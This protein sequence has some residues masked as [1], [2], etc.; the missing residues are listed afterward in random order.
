MN[1]TRAALAAAAALTACVST[2][3]PAAIDRMAQATMHSSFREQGIAKLDRLA[4]MPEPVALA[5]TADDSVLYVGERAGR[6]RAI[7][8]G[9]LD[10][11]PVLDLTDQVVVEGEG[12]LL[13][14]A[15]APDG[16][17]LYVSFT[18][19]QHTVRLVEAAVAAFQAE[20]E[21]GAFGMVTTGEGHAEQVK[22]LPVGAGLVIMRRPIAGG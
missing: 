16:G 13:G 10:P 2:P 14:V 5:A 20:L 19:A 7:R 22:Q 11:D 1:S 15:V 12:G 18:D 8:D 9:R 21:R 6:V 3:D 17:H 4:R